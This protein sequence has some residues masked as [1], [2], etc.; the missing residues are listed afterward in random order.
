LH[1]SITTQRNFI[2]SKHNRFIYTYVYVYMSTRMKYIY[3]YLHIKLPKKSKPKKQEKGEI[4]SMCP[5]SIKAPL[6]PRIWIWG[7]S[8]H[9]EKVGLQLSTTRA[10]SKAKARPLKMLQMP[11][12]W[13][14]EWP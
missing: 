13:W 7:R 2:G 1:L 5:R 11:L 3:L 8:Q 14:G 6:L 4:L 12:A 9:W 10:T